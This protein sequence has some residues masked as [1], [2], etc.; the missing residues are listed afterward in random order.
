MT[1]LLRKVERMFI[2][3]VLQ[4]PTKMKPQRQNEF[5]EKKITIT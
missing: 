2:V 5:S 4:F 1:N 3:N